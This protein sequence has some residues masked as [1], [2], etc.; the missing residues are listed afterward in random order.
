MQSLEFQRQ[1]SIDLLYK[2][3]V[4]FSSSR[5]KRRPCI[6]R[7]Q[8]RPSISCIFFKLPWVTVDQVF[9][10]MSK[11]FV[12]MLQEIVNFKTC[13]P[14]CLQS[15]IANKIMKASRAYFYLVGFQL[16]KKNHTVTHK[17]SHSHT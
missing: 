10:T 2:G 13:R 7:V 11:L 15:T 1:C 5:Q 12:E 4:Y 16:T 14:C 3:K 9:C 17:C 8:N 6:F